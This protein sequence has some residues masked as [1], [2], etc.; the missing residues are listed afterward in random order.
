MTDHSIS[1][2]HANMRFLSIVL[3]LVLFVTVL[4]CKNLKNLKFEIKDTNARQRRGL[5][6]DFI[7]EVVSIPV[8]LASVAIDVANDVNRGTFQYKL[9]NSVNVFKE[10]CSEYNINKLI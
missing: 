9:Y 8:T 3:I 7:G 10:R 1:I 4:E 2:Q 5:L 6:A